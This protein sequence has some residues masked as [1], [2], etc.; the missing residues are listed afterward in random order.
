[1][2]DTANRGSDDVTESIY[3]TIR[4]DEE[5]KVYI[6]Y[7]SV[8]GEVVDKCQISS[9]AVEGHTDDVTHVTVVYDQV[10]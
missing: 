5:K 4:G 9:I 8:R 2:N 3:T 1:M 10:D 6:S 7:G